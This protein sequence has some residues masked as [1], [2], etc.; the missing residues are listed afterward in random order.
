M[1]IEYVQERIPAEYRQHGKIIVRGRE[2]EIG[3]GNDD[4]IFVY[5]DPASY[6]PRM[7]HV[8]SENHRFGYIGVE[9]FDFAEGEKVDE[10]FIQDPEEAEPLLE[11]LRY[12][13]KIRYLMQWYQ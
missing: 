1:R 3:A 4:D 2:F 7:L 5:L 11:G 10:M 12:P 9:S 8:L 13:S 6:R